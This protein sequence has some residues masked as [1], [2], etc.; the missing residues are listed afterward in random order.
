[1]RELTLGLIALFTTYVIVIVLL[2]IH[3]HIVVL[4]HSFIFNWVMIFVSIASALSIPF[5][6]AAIQR[7][8]KINMIRNFWKEQ[9][10][11]VQNNDDVDIDEILNDLI[12][13]RE[14]VRSIYNAFD[15]IQYTQ[16]IRYIK[17][18]SQKSK[19]QKLIL[20]YTVSMLDGFIAKKIRLFEI[21]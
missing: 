2:L 5:V 11:L 13:I 6:Y 15:F 7:R 9:K 8:R 17:Q 4:E 20:E 10:R 14:Y 19:D 3:M 12:T 21:N 18:L 16:R 1:M